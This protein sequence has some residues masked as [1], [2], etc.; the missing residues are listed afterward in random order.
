MLPLEGT[1]TSTATAFWVGIVI[2]LVHYAIRRRVIE[3]FG[4]GF[5][6]IIV[7]SVVQW[8]ATDY[9]AAYGLYIGIAGISYLVVSAIILVFK[10]VQYSA[11][12]L[13]RTVIHSTEQQQYQRQKLL[14]CQCTCH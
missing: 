4:T 11:N 8:W 10:A 1:V 14:E 9:I 3:L 5:G 7:G 2:A 6:M 13:S 12:I